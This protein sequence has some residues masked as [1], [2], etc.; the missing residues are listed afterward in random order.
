MSPRC[1][2][3]LVGIGKKISAS[4]KS[5]AKHM[6]DLKMDGMDKLSHQDPKLKAL[7]DNTPSTSGRFRLQRVHQSSSRFPIFVNVLLWWK[8]VA[9]SAV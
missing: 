2:D 3:E 7:L 6:T 1:A 5:L 8:P 4:F 9:Q